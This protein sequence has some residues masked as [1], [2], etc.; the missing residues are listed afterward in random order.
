MKIYIVG[1]GMD[2]KKTLTAKA[3]EVIKSADILIGAER[4]LVP[5][6]SLE[7]PTFASWKAEEIAAYLK[8]NKYYGN[9]VVLMSGDTGFYSGAKKLKDVLSAY[10]TELICGI[11][12]PVYFCS[13]IGFP[14]HDMNFISLHGASGNVVR[15]VCRN[16]YCFFL[17]GGDVTPG[18]ICRRL[19]DYNMGEIRVFIGENLAYENERIHIGKAAEYTALQTD[20]LAVMITENSQYERVIRSGISDE[21]FI[22][23]NVPMTKSEVRSAVISKL[24]ISAD[25]ICWDI[26]SGT[27]SVSV[28][29]ALHAFNGKVFSV[30]K[31]NEAIMLTRKNAVKFGCDNIEIINGTAP[32]CLVD[33]PAPDR[34]FIG[35]SCGRMNEILSAVRQKNQSALVVITA[36]SIETL[37]QAASA[38]ERPDIVQLSVTRTKKIGGHTMLS[39][40]NPVFIIKGALN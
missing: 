7:K 4:M 36:V 15:N 24:E 34:V 9:A 38:L 13:R 17:L 8:E 29:M 23:G 5:F 28:E 6:S 33:F 18:E 1:I 11:P 14:W 21:N 16:E 2:G 30:D 31:N 10:D 25:C 22:R 3:Y 27:G 12:S 32:D 20:K 40:E 35:G 37:E 39:A 26:G 19:C